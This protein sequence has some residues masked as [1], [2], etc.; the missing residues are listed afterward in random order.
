[1]PSVCRVMHCCCSTPVLSSHSVPCQKSLQL[2][3]EWSWSDCLG[4]GSSWLLRRPVDHNVRNEIP[5]EVPPCEQAPCAPRSDTSLSYAET[6]F[7]P[8]TVWAE[9]YRW[10][11]GRVSYAREI[12]CIDD[13]ILMFAA[14]HKL[15]SVGTHTKRER[16][17]I[18][19]SFVT[20]RLRSIDISFS[21]SF[22][23]STEKSKVRCRKHN[24]VT[25]LCKTSSLKNITIIVGTRNQRQQE[26]FIVIRP[27]F[28]HE[29]ICIFWTS[30]YV[31]VHICMLLSAVVCQQRSS[32]RIEYHQSLTL[33]RASVHQQ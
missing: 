6:R 31:L 4:F 2:S 10:E 12:T 13:C 32:Y 18:A 11:S 28:L 33:L 9:P 8:Q 19:G 15:Q 22:S 26:I 30:Q 20:L 14:A 24:K 3:N 27:Y 1:M 23:V 17:W 7:L 25:S 5:H 16:P 21:V 29:N